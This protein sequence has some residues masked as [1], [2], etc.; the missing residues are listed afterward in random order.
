MD[1]IE[2][3]EMKMMRRLFRFRKKVDETLTVYCTGTAR[4]ARTIWTNWNYLSSRKQLPNAFGDLLG[5]YVTKDRMLCWS[6]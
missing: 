6:H 4:M 1:K 2:G 3:W 5:G